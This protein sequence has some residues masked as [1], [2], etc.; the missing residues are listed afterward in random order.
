MAGGGLQCGRGEKG[1]KRIRGGKGPVHRRQ[2]V[3][4]PF[5]DTSPALSRER[6]HF[7]VVADLRLELSNIQPD[8]PLILSK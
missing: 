6:N 3:T 7:N 5:E 1:A 4:R 2:H 8:I